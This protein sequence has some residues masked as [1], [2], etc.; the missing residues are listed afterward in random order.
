MP[1]T[2]GPTHH[3]CDLNRVELTGKLA[4]NPQVLWAHEELWVGFLLGVRGGWLPTPDGG[5]RKQ[6]SLIKGVATG[7]LAQQ[8][9]TWTRGT[10]V[11]VCGSL[12]L[13]MGGDG[14][15]RPRWELAVRATCVERLADR[16]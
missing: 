8:L 5:L 15:T 16:S 6:V 4:D 11:S 10:A 3:D 7:D 12:D 1:H 13:V 2:D 14:L 9:L